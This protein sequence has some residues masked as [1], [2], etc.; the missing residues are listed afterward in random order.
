MIIFSRFYNSIFDDAAQLGYEYKNITS[1][2]IQS[3][4]SKLAA[5]VSNT[6]IKLVSSSEELTVKPDPELVKIHTIYFPCHVEYDDLESDRT[7]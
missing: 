5:A 4:I 1:S 7:H 3:K 2:S 6:V